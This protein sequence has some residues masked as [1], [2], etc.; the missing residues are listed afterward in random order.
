LPQIGEQF[1]FILG[2]ETEREGLNGQLYGGGAEPELCPGVFTHG[3]G[4]V[5]GPDKGLKVGGVGRGWC[6]LFTDRERNGLRMFIDAKKPRGRRK[7]YSRRTR[8]AMS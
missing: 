2:D 8:V 1:L 6:S 4:L 3:D 5:E 7:F